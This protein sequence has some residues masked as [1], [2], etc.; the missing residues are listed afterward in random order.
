M[1]H[2]NTKN[3]QTKPNQQTKHQVDSNI[4][5]SRFQSREYCQGQR[6]PVHNDKMVNLSREDNNLKYLWA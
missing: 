5:Q 3:N 2:G 4:R 6:S 1:Y